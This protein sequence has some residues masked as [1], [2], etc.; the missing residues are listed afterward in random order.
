MPMLIHEQI[1]SFLPHFVLDSRSALDELVDKCPL[2]Y[3]RV[4]LTFTRP[5][6]LDGFNRLKQV[7]EVVFKVKE[8]SSWK[9]LS[10]VFRLPSVEYLSVY[11]HTLL[12]GE[13]EQGVSESF[14]EL[15]TQS[16][17]SVNQRHFFKFAVASLEDVEVE[18]ARLLRQHKRLVGLEFNSITK[19]LQSFLAVSSPCSLVHLSLR[20]CNLKPESVIRVAKALRVQ[21]RIRLLDISYNQ[22]VGDLGMAA[23]ATALQENSTLKHLGISHT[24]ISS[25][26]AQLLAEMLK[27][28]E[29]LE[30]C[31]I[32]DPIE[33]SGVLALLDM[34]RTNCGLRNVVIADTSTSR[35]VRPDAVCSSL[36][37]NNQLKELIIDIGL[38]HELLVPTKVWR[39]VD[40]FV[41][42]RFM[43]GNHR[44]K[45][46]LMCLC[47]VEK[48]EQRT[49]L[50]PTYY[51]IGR[52][53]LEMYNGR[54]IKTLFPA[55][56]G[57]QVGGV[58][59][60]QLYRC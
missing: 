5:G 4:K 28:N 39:W 50:E 24:Q 33:T 38:R 16:I 29:T 52:A 60:A 43:Q 40:V 31:E 23:L 7:K 58:Q 8:G 18:I 45:K 21:K 26:S 1:A 10:A 59:W 19:R 3:L 56:H 49:M 6:D 27:L 46:S 30:V 2:E 51:C 20:D 44:Y 41:A 17:A 35:R 15:I 53:A 12:Q 22:R 13:Y 47:K 42:N 55:V 34:L 36:E 9:T 14:A 37:H 48:I 11:I 25:E 54:Q 57:F 32:I